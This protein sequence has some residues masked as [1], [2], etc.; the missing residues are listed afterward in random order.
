LPVTQEVVGSSPIVP[1]INMKN[2][3]AEKRFFWFY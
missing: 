3:N 1:A 2:K